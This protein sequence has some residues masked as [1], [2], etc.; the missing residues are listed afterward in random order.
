MLMSDESSILYDLT[1]CH[2]QGSHNIEASCNINLE[3]T[4]AK[5]RVL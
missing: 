5:F 4:S 1:Y 3:V 2:I